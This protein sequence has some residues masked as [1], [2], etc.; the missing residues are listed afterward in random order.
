MARFHL[1]GLTQKLLIRVIV[2]GVDSRLIRQRDDII[3]QQ[4]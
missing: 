4:L 1:F 2:D 3:R